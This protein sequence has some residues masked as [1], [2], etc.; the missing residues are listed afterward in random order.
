MST[1]DIAI[2]AAFGL[3]LLVWPRFVYLGSKAK[4]DARQLRMIRGAGAILL[5]VAALYQGIQ[6]AGG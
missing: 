2:P 5:L 3:V 4:P 1:I 6:L